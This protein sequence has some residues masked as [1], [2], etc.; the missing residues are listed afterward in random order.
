MEIEEL[1]LFDRANVRHRDFENFDSNCKRA[2]E[3]TGRKRTGNVPVRRLRKI[4]VDDLVS[5]GERD[6]ECRREV[7]A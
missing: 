6:T 3:K 1:P 5:E 7:V 4:V 2:D